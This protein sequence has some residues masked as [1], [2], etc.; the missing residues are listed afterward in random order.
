ML[1][2]WSELKCVKCLHIGDL[3][4]LIILVSGSETEG[5]SYPKSHSE[6]VTELEFKVP[7]VR[8]RVCVL[9]VPSC[10]RAV[11][12]WRVQAHQGALAWPCSLWLSI[13]PM[14]SGEVG[15]VTPK[16][17]KELNVWHFTNWWRRRHGNARSR[18]PGSMYHA[19]L[20]QQHPAQRLDFPLALLDCHASPR[21]KRTGMI[22]YLQVTD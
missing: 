6:K 19:S 14:P 7:R 1:W 10:P 17:S 22:L 5:G 16:S 2:K 21:E 20:C 12:Y 3:L 11:S 15:L 8:C 9:S 13:C 18:G 4:M